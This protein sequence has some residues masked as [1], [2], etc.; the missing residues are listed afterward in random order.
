MT[1]IRDML[2]FY[3]NYNNEYMRTGVTYSANLNQISSKEWKRL[4]ETPTVFAF[5]QGRQIKESI[6]EKVLNIYAF[7]GTKVIAARHYF[8]DAYNKYHC[9]EQCVENGSV[10]YNEGKYYYNGVKIDRIY[11][12]MEECAKMGAFPEYDN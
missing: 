1:D 7:S 6:N 12:T 4:L 11:G 8:I 2:E 10:N 5:L 3:I 9:L